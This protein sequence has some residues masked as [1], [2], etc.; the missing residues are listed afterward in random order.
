[1]DPFSTGLGDQQ[2]S[3]G[4]RSSRE[5]RFDQV[6]DPETTQVRGYCSDRLA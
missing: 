2:S 1:M 6:F 3:L 5:Y 4:K